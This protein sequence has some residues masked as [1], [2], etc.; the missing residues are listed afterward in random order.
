V[1]GRG[2]AA[3]RRSHAAAELANRE[4]LRDVIVGAELETQHLVDLVVARSQHDDRDVATSPQLLADL[5]AVHLRQHEVED[6][7]IDSVLIEPAKRLLPIV[8][9]DHAVPVALERI[10]Q[11]LLDG[12]LVVHEE[13]GGGVGHEPR[14]D[15]DLL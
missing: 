2:S 14:V 15:R 9:L 11:Q 3:Q 10:R 1:L 8:R 12:L 5:E 4:R 13:D 6:D 7:E